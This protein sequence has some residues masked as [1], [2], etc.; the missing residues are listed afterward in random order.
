MGVQSDILMVVRDMAPSSRMTL[1][2]T[3]I[4]DAL[5]VDHG[6]DKKQAAN[7][8]DALARKGRIK[9]L[10]SGNMYIT[11]AGL[12][13]LSGS[14]ESPAQQEFENQDLETAVASI[15]RLAESNEKMRGALTKIRDIINQALK[16]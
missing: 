1:H 13:H 7:A 11:K 3:D 9:K 5:V 4:I 2:R 8:I 14:T 12:V 15:G 10:A 16:E 6:Y